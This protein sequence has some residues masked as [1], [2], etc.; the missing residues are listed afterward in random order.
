MWWKCYKSPNIMNKLSKKQKKKCYLYFF[1]TLSYNFRYIQ[2]SHLCYFPYVKKGKLIF[3]LTNLVF[4]AG[5]SNIPPWSLICLTVSIILLLAS[6]CFWVSAK[7]HVLGTKVKIWIFFSR[8]HK[9]LWYI[10]FKLFKNSTESFSRLAGTGMIS[11]ASSAS[12][13]MCSRLRST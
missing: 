12:S 3:M 9:S 10:D 11:W 13:N 6:K 5:V 7:L 4:L 8:V 1:Y 2:E